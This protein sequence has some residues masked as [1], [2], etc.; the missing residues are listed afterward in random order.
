M[1]PPG[2]EGDEMIQEPLPFQAT[3]GYIQMEL[4]APEDATPGAEIEP[5]PEREG[6]SG[7]EA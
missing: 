3:P 7:P 5:P 2:G 1:P 6:E 4:N